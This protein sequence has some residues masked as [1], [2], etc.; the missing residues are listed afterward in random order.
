MMRATKFELVVNMYTAK[1]I[2]LT[3][4]QGPLSQADV[5]IE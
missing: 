5:V 2:G 4:P 3:V 1:P